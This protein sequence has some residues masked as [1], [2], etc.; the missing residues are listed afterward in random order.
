[1]QSAHTA[2]Y[3]SLSHEHLAMTAGHRRAP[4]PH[5]ILAKPAI[6][7]IIAAH[8][9]DGLPAVSMARLRY[10]SNDLPAT[11]TNQ[12]VPA[13]RD[14]MRSCDPFRSLAATTRPQYVMREC[15]R[16]KPARPRR[17]PQP[18][19]LGPVSISARASFGAYSLMIARIISGQL[20]T[21]PP[22]SAGRPRPPRGRPFIH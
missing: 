11:H 17:M 1:M 7:L 22:K 20:R 5:S 3:S 15:N 18:N 12:C 16:R 6:W 2:L 8:P 19:C 10:R 4:T 14:Q 13:G 21:L 9:D